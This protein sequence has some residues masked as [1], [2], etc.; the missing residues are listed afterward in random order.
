LVS[1]GV[2]CCGDIILNDVW[3]DRYDVVVRCWQLEASERPRF[4]GLAYILGEMLSEQEE[5]TL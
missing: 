3:L 2:G 1:V 4:K 5:S